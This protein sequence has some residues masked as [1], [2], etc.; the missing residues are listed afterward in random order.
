MDE[1]RRE[2]IENIKSKILDLLEL[3][4]D[5]INS[6]STREVD[7]MVSET[8]KNLSNVY[9]TLWMVTEEADRL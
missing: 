2:L 6:R 1:N 8:C 4:L 9:S 3:E 7:L 5:A